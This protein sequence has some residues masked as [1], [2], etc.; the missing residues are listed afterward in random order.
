VKIKRYSFAALLIIV[1]AVIG[2]VSNQE[3]T[4]VNSGESEQQ[5][6][7]AKVT[8]SF[9]KNPRSRSQDENNFGFFVG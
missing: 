7:Q 5:I 8:V 1:S 2:W 9:A 4:R 3:S 6:V